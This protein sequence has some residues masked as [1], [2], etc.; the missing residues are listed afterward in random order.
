MGL[1]RFRRGELQRVENPRGDR[2]NRRKTIAAND[3][4]YGQALKA[5]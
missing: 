5:A 4:D 3:S 1:F 2:R